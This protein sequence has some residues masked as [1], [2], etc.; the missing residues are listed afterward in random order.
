M[1]SSTTFSHPGMRAPQHPTLQRITQ[2][3][4]ELQLEIFD[5][6]DQLGNEVLANFNQ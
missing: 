5:G 3:T 2:Q 6:L 4:L 1:A